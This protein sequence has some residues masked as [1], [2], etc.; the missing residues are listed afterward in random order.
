MPLTGAAIAEEK[1]GN[2]QREQTQSF[3]APA[4]AQISDAIVQ[5]EPSAIASPEL[6]DVSAGRAAFERSCT[7]C[8]DAARSLDKAKT[9]GGWLRTIQRMA[10]KDGADIR[11][12]DVVP[13]ASYLASVAGASGAVADGG[14]EADGGWSFGATV[15]TL[16]RSASDESLVEHPGFFADVWVTAAYQSAGPWRATVTSCTS[17]HTT[18]GAPL[19]LVEGS[20]TLDLRHLGCGCRCDDGRELLLKAGRFVT[21]FGAY[22]A[23]SHPGINRTVSSPL[24][25]NMGRRV[26]VPNSSPPQQQP[27][28]PMPFSDEGIDF[29]FRTPVTDELT[30][31]LDLYAVNGLQ[32]AG[33]NVFNRSRLYFDNNEEPSLGARITLGS[34]FFRLGASV[35]G[36]N[37][38]DEQT[39]PLDHFLAGAD[40]TCQ[41]TDRLRFYFEYAMRRQE[42]QFVAGADEDTY[43]TVTELEWRVWDCPNISLLVRYD[44]LEHRHPVF[45]DASLDR[46]TTGINVG[47]PG[48]SLLMINHE[49]WMPDGEDDVDLIGV[50]WVV[51]L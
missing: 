41:I 3:V 24:I 19:E 38:Q 23:M 36:G 18:N 17:C 35:L 40:A 13:I 32:G 11:T 20:A 47:L 4:A 50:R 7:D 1:S 51:S 39:P 6:G 9:Y 22:A 14:D 21:P 42:S 10:A 34:D 37:S 46:F 15:S 30:F 33:P 2:V 16:H 29:I 28:L 26:L 27:V 31:T 48:G 8:H 12:S 5:P 45:G 25:F 44:T 43:G 49:L